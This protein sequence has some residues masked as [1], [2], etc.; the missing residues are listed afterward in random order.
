MR[1]R[2]GGRRKHGTGGITQLFQESLQSGRGGHWLLTQ[3]GKGSKPANSKP[4]KKRVPK[5]RERG[6][7]YQKKK[8]KSGGGT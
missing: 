7:F 1:V 6:V 3:D 2:K 4:K 8:T 5:K